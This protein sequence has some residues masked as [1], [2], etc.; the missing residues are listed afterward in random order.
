VKYLQIAQLIEKALKE[1]LPVSWHPLGFLHLKL[2]SEQRLH[3]W[4][5]DG[6]HPQK[7]LFPIHDHIFNLESTVLTGCVTNT[8][9]SVV[10][11]C[12]APFQL[13]EVRYQEKLSVLSPTGCRVGVSPADVKT[14]C[15]GQTYRVPVGQFHSTNASQGTLTATFALT[16][17]RSG[18]PRVVGNL[19]QDELKYHRQHC[20]PTLAKRLLQRVLVRL[21]EKEQAS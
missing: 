19:S 16:T 3:I 15:A 10:K 4:P 8:V 21:Q 7:P 11:S 5:E 14:I 9:Y 20:E 1:R 12:D 6:G 18:I 2:A 17:G 13:W